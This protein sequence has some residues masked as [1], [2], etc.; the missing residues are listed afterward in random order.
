MDPGPEDDGV[1]FR[2]Q[3]DRAVPRADRD[4][5][6]DGPRMRVQAVV[7]TAKVDRAVDGPGVEHRVGL[8]RE[9]HRAVDGPTVVDPG[10]LAR[11][12]GRRL[13]LDRGGPRDHAA[14]D[15]V[16]VACAHGGR[17]R[18][19]LEQDA[20]GSAAVRCDRAAVVDHRVGRVQS[21]VGVGDVD[22]DRLDG[23]DWPDGPGDA[24]RGHTARVVELAA[25]GQ[26]HA[27]RGALARRG[28]GGDRPAGEIV[29]EAGFAQV[30]GVGRRIVAIDRDRAGVGH[31]PARAEAGRVGIERGRG[32]RNRPVVLQGDVAEVAG[33]QLERDAAVVAEQSRGVGSAGDRHSGDAEGAGIGQR[34]GAV[35]VELAACA[36]GELDQRA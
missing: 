34:Q 36:G 25:L 6:C 7:A 28:A 29:H 19:P 13:E 15:Q 24:D 1:V 12:G 22:A 23:S 10:R 17:G 5:A 27:G 35:V 3:R 31:V 20:D 18:P 2:S 21:K 4:H 8:T 9:Q 30:H 33:E 14:V 16:V 11:A 32:E 26:P